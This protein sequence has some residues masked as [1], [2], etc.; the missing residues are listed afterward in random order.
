M[1]KIEGQ[2]VPWN[3]VP[4]DTSL[5][6]AG[7]RAG[8]SGAWPVGAWHGALDWRIGPTKAST[9]KTC[10]ELSEMVLNSDRQI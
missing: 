9:T 8:P 2:Y 3:G 6:L 5:R 4:T 7:K 10:F 1:S